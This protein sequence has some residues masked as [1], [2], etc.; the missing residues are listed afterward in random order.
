MESEIGQDGPG[1]TGFYIDGALVKVVSFLDSRNL[2]WIMPQK[3]Y[4]S[5]DGVIKFVKEKDGALDLC[6]WLE[7]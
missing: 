5:S 1:W 3:N 7:N 6:R 4:H 2:D